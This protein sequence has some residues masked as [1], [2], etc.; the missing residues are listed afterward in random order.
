[1]VVL[2]ERKHKNV[3]K[4]RLDAFDRFRIAVTGQYHPA[5]RCE[6]F[7]AGSNLVCRICVETL[8][9][10]KLAIIVLEKDD[11]AWYLQLDLSS[12][13]PTG[14]RRRNR[15]IEFNEIPDI[16]FFIELFGLAFFLRG[17][18]LDILRPLTR[19]LLSSRSVVDVRDLL[20]RNKFPRYDLESRAVCKFEEYVLWIDSGRRAQI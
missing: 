14:R 11:V 15:W 7:V 5:S 20:L 1:M 10:H 2:V 19:L 13:Q 6:R 18:D 4:I 12:E 17:L 8:P 16:V 3:V 9:S